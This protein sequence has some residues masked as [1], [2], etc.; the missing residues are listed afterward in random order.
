MTGLVYPALDHESLARLMVLLHT[1]PNL[2]HDLGIAARDAAEK[3]FS[4]E[5]YV[6]QLY[7]LY[8]IEHQA[9]RGNPQ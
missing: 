7:T 2:R 6:L 9:S 8:G 3:R 4:V 1:R 5:A